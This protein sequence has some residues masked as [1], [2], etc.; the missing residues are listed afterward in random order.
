MLI[1]W[2]VSA[3]RAARG[4]VGAQRGGGG[5]KAEFF[6]GGGRMRGPKEEARETKCEQRMARNLA[7]QG[8]QR[9][10]RG[11]VRSSL[12]GTKRRPFPKSQA[13]I[14]LSR[15]TA[16]RNT[17]E[18]QILAVRGA[19]EKADG[20]RH[21]DRDGIFPAQS[22]G[23]I[24]SDANIVEDVLKLRLGFRS[25]ELIQTNLVLVDRLV[26]DCPEACAKVNREEDIPWRSAVGAKI[27]PTMTM[28]TLN[29]RPCVKNRRDIC[30]ALMSPGRVDLQR[31]ER[32]G[33]VETK[34]RFRSKSCRPDRH[35]IQ[36]AFPRRANHIRAIVH[37]G[38]GPEFWSAQRG[39][40]FRFFLFSLI[41]KCNH[42]AVEATTFPIEKA[43]PPARQPDDSRFTAGGVPTGLRLELTSGRTVRREDSV[44][45]GMDVRIVVKEEEEGVEHGARHVL[46]E[47]GHDGDHRY[48][49]TELAVKCFVR[50]TDSQITQIP[51][52]KC[53]P[54]EIGT[55]FKATFRAVTST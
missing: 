15:V 34:V 43:E 29:I 11:R 7:A 38:E 46:E 16:R 42:S 33:G 20:S 47:K 51:S 45:T 1:S 55:N 49:F 13:R 6:H 18:E 44:Q 39:G 54:G 40:S 4:R 10:I 24:N 17:T 5:V 28:P 23:G 35:P 26:G 41:F 52:P 2:F 3:H 27:G 53:I 48:S 50:E 31:P 19:T 30:P 36:P 37:L 22:G 8:F 32:H 14:S 9:G 21:R 25:D 12:S